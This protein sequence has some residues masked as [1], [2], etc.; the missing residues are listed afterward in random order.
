MIETTPELALHLG[1]EVTTLATCIRVIR[2]D[3]TVFAFTSGTEDLSI[4]GV[5]Y[6]AKGGFSPAASVE[7]TQSLAVDSLEI[8][9][10][11]DDEGITEDDLRRGLF[12]GAG[13]DVFVV[14]WRDVSQG[15]LML[16]RGT[17]GEVTLKRAQF[18]AEIRGLSQAF[19]TQVGELY[20]PGCNVRRL[21]DERCKVDLTPFTHTLTVSAVH[22]SRRQFAHA[23][24]L[25]ADHTFSFGTVKFLTGGN[26]GY[27]AEVKSYA[28]GVFTCQLPLPF[29][30]AVGDSFHAIRGCD[31]TF[32]TCR[33]VFAN[34]LNFR[35]FPHLPGVD[36]MLRTST[37]APAVPTPETPYVPPVEPPPSIPTPPAPPP[38]PPPSPPPGSTSKTTA[39]PVLQAKGLSLVWQDRLGESDEPA[40]SM[41]FFGATAGS[42][43]QNDNGTNRLTIVTFDGRRCLK[44]EYP[45]NA[46]GWLNHRAQ[47]LP[48]RYREL[49]LCVDVLYPSDFDLTNVL[50]GD[51][52]GKSMFG[53]LSGHTDFQKPGVPIERAWRGA[54]CVPEDQIGSENGVNF[55]Y[56][57]ATG[58]IE[59][60]WYAHAVGA[61]VNGVNQLRADVFSRLYNIPG[62]RGYEKVKIPKGRWFRLELY[63][64]IDS[65]RGDGTLEMWIDGNRITHAPNLDLG[66]WV[67]DRGLYKG[68]TLPAAPPG[69]PNSGSNGQKY[70][71]GNGDL[72]NTNVGQDAQKGGHRFCGIFLRDMLGGVSTADSQKPRKTAAYYTHN[73]RVYGRA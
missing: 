56:R 59:F 18:A 12:D 9:A 23:A 35:G 21:G 62:Y 16:R 65:D 22:Q 54:V 6:K 4:D 51:N 44:S 38:P 25:Q 68:K 45:A 55:T 71:F 31:R 13:I 73:W 43:Q 39:A 61:R 53:L 69:T 20:Q 29:E 58:N 36:E 19:A 52:F 64:R 48:Q 27:E 5:C 37:T 63:G 8:E 34:Q 72:S 1:G 46:P 42:R 70:S 26:A 28:G 49:G 24:N 60:D 66:G 57:A 17:L 33:A 67:G 14:N 3:G 11:L 30:I 15:K 40:S 47:Y 2:R 7:T 32:N 41:Q 50:G 10:I